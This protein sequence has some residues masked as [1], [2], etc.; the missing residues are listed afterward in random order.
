MKRSHIQTQR[1]VVAEQRLKF[2]HQTH[3]VDGHAVQGGSMFGELRP[4]ASDYRSETRIS[5][6][7][8]FR[9]KRAASTSNGCCNVAGQF[10]L[11][12]IVLVDVSR[13]GIDMDEMTLAYL[14]PETWFVF[15]RVVP[16][17][18]DHISRVQELVGWLIVEQT[19]SARR[20][21]RRG[22]AA[23]LLHLGRCTPRQFR[24]GK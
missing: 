12:S 3:R 15:D 23:L 1:H 19:D 4:I 8:A 17:G 6:E 22:L 11:R 16:N 21:G 13:N 5:L 7:G 14:V 2:V 20:N 18:D 24:F 9:S 10:K